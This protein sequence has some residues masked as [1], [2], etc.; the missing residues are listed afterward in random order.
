MHAWKSCI[1]LYLLSGV[2]GKGVDSLG[3]AS[4]QMSQQLSSRL[5]RA[6]RSAACL[7]RCFHTA[8]LWIHCSSLRS[9]TPVIMLREEKKKDGTQEQ[10][11]CIVYSF[12]IWHEF[13]WIVNNTWKQPRSTWKP[14]VC[15][16]MRRTS[17]GKL[18]SQLKTVW[19]QP[20]R[21]A[22]EPESIRPL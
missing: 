13:V 9:S 22:L 6:R 16:V 21:G 2:K 19:C 7:Q 18:Y 11:D 20:L 15:V 10:L 3:F 1:C 8:C 12:W 14:G 5:G 4:L 17:A